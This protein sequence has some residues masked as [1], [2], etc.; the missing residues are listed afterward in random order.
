MWCGVPKWLSYVLRTALGSTGWA[1]LTA[2]KPSTSFQSP[3]A[4]EQQPAREAIIAITMSQYPRLRRCEVAHTAL[5]LQHTLGCPPIR[6]RDGRS[7]GTDRDSAGTTQTLC[8]YAEVSIIESHIYSECMISVRRKALFQRN[9][10][11]NSPPPPPLFYLFG[12]KKDEKKNHCNKFHQLAAQ[13]KEIH[14][15]GLLKG[16]EKRTNT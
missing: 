13:I 16:G 5:P 12:W 9:F 3:C 15:K 11:I 2:L 8:V 10:I 7:T 1:K 14:R 6:P 4:H